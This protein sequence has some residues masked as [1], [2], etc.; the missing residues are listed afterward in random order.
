MNIVLINFLYCFI[1]IVM[2]L[3]GMAAG[4]KL[5][6]SKWFTPFDTDEELKKGNIAV[7][8]VIGGMMIGIGTAVGLVV[9]MGLN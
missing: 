6:D 5:M 3:C 8:I 9:G 2:T 7:G 4:Y 1:G